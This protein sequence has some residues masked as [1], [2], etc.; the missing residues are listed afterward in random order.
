VSPKDGGRLGAPHMADIPLVFDNIAQSGSRAEGPTA[1][2]MAERMSEA[3]IAFARSGDPNSKAIPHWAPYRL[4]RRETMVFDNRTRMEDDPRGAERR[5]FA[6]V[7]FVQ[8][9]T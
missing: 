2:P 7:P 6:K 4:P 8:A 1:Q 5:F 3:F 9:G